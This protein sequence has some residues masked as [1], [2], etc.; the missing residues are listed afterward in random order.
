MFNIVSLLLTH[1][2]KK[3]ENPE[4]SP[5]GT[6]PI[7]IAAF[8][9]MIFQLLFI[10]SIYTVVLYRVFSSAIGSILIKIFGVFAVCAVIITIIAIIAMRCKKGNK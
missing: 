9:V 8:A 6:H 4:N 5:K 3:N 10:L 1:N 7:V 2:L